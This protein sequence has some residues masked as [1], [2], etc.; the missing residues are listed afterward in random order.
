MTADELAPAIQNL[1]DHQRQLDMDGIFVGVS[2]QALDEVLTELP[3]LLEALRASEWQPI[4]TA[5]KQR[6]LTVEEV[7]QAWANGPFS[8]NPW[9][10]FTA[11]LNAILQG[12]TK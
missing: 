4:E 2:R 5:A 9:T 3:R 11:R 12:E 10:D 1:T 7:R 6:L 8:T